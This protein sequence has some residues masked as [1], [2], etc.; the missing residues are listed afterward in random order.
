[1]NSEL[2][3]VM[4]TV[5][6]MTLAFNEEHHSHVFLSNTNNVGW[7][8]IYDDNRVYLIL[9]HGAGSA[10]IYYVIYGDHGEPIS[11]KSATI[12]VKEHLDLKF[13]YEHNHLFFFELC[14]I[15]KKT[16]IRLCP[17]V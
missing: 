11:H 10:D 4:D 7:K 14:P 6:T 5:K 8:L 3:K 17:E 15:I 13:S 12:E 16:N 9:L 2:L 1:M